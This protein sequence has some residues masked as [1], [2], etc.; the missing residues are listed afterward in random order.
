MFERLL[1]WLGILLKPRSVSEWQA[2]TAGL[3]WLVGQDRDM[4]AWRERYGKPLPVSHP[5]Y[6]RAMQRHGDQWMERN[7]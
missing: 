3:W 2:E 7:R 5:D 4:P 1:V 6:H